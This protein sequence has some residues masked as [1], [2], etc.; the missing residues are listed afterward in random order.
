MIRTAIIEMPE[1]YLPQ[2]IAVINELRRAQSRF[3][4][5]HSP[6]EG[7]AVIAEEVQELWDEIRLKTGTKENQR[8]EAIQ[9]AA[10]AMRF[11]VDLVPE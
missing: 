9:V 10:V 3:G 6:H 8:K 7:Y 11:L 5:Y 2:V 1:E 4:P